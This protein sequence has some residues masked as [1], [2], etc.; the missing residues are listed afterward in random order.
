MKQFKYKI[1]AFALSILLGINSF[2]TVAYCD[3]PYYGDGDN[4]EDFYTYDND[5]DRVLIEVI[6]GDADWNDFINSCG[7]NYAYS[8]AKIAAKFSQICAF[9]GGIV[10][11]DMSLN[12]N[13]YSQYLARLDSYR[14]EGIEFGE[15]N[16]DR[17]ANNFRLFN[18]GDKDPRTGEILSNNKIV[19]SG[20]VALTIK[21][22][23]K[24]K[25]DETK[26][27]IQ[28]VYS[29]DF[30]S[31]ASVCASKQRFQ[32][33]KNVISSNKDKLCCIVHFSVLADDPTALNSK[34]S[35]QSGGKEAFYLLVYENV[36]CLQVNEH[37]QDL[38]M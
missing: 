20:D 23:C 5:P 13:E 21:A 9:L 6:T 17:L 3:N 31:I 27:D 29:L 32:S 15:W 8:Q 34:A 25:I 18:K 24:E 22:F 37:R 11:G 36:N 30:N 10:G 14:A 33:I 4:N 26:D 7:N 28:Y 16:A 12:W 38:H 1:I 35:V 19:M 2:Y